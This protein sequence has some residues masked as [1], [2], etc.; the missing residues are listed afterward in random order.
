M[1]DEKYELIRGD[2]DNFYSRVF[3]GV[4]SEIPL[5]LADGMND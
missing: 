5:A 4:K 1:T 3:K 2:T